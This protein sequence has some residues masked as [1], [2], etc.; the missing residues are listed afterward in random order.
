MALH[1]EI[2]AVTDRVIER[3]RPGRTWPSLTMV[4]PSPRANLIV[5]ASSS[6]SS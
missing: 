1:P 5:L 2:A 4:P 6:V 3:S